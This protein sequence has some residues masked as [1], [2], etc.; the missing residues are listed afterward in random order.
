LPMIKEYLKQRRAADEL[1]KLK[2]KKRDQQKPGSQRRI[3]ESIMRAVKP[4][5][6]KFCAKELPAW[7]KPER[8]TCSP[9]CRKALER[10]RRRKAKAAAARRGSRKG[11]QAFRGRRGASRGPLLKRRSLRRI[12]RKSRRT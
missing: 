7:S 3:V 2:R 11:A 5:F 4:R 12:T 1:I 10:D 8:K 6:C 9:A